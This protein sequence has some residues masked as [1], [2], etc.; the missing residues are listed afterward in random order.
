MSEQTPLQI[1]EWPQDPI[2][3]RLLTGH[4]IQLGLGRPELYSKILASRADVIVF[5][6]T[7]ERSHWIP[8]RPEL[9]ERVLVTHSSQ[10]GK[11]SPGYE[12]LRKILGHGIVTKEGTEWKQS[13]KL[14]GRYFG[15]TQI[16]SRESELRAH[17]RDTL[18]EV[19]T[20]PHSI[21]IGPLMSRIALELFA[22]YLLRLDDRAKTDRLRRALDGIFRRFVLWQKF[23]SP[24][25]IRLFGDY[26]FAFNHLTG[27]FVELIQSI[28]QAMPENHPL[29]ASYREAG[30][31]DAG[32]Q[33]DLRNLLIAGHDTSANVL[34][35]ALYEF[36][37]RPEFQA[38]ARTSTPFLED[39]I[40]E[41]LRLYPAIANFG[42]SAFTDDTWGE[43]SIRKGDSV[44][45]SPFLLHRMERFF[46]D[47]LRFDPLRPQD[48]KRWSE[49][50]FIP[51]GKGARSCVG[52]GFA[53]R[54]MKWILS[55]ILESYDIT[56]SS[57]EI[58]ETDLYPYT[59]L[60]SRN[61]IRLKFSRR[62]GR[63]GMPNHHD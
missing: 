43:T 20:E 39:W 11:R 22:R 59:T 34:Q 2:S 42:R 33:G 19:L 52:R 41:T 61:P 55:E 8:L 58:S 49:E 53:L 4:L 15:L 46:P 31:G 47:A 54:E 48:S 44:A 45:V 62:I 17:V 9:I 38:Q 28:V 16:D 51:F 63:P 32:L 13:Q 60:Q 1:Q 40:L 5:R 6:I 10:Y 30:I 24:L 57:P 25:T 27:T 12:R 14:L 26:S 21:P 37:R 56:L 23:P 29:R 50:A 35:F 7:P 18:S 36:A 3:G